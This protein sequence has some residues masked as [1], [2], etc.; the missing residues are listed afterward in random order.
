MVLLLVA[1]VLALGVWLVALAAARG[2]LT[3]NGA[4]GIRTPA[5][6][7]SQEAWVAAHRAALPLVAWGG[8]AVVAA[9][10]VVLLGGFLEP[11]GLET[12]GI[13]LVLAEGVLVVI[14]A[15]VAHRAAVQVPAP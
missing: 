9:A 6:Q 13:T 8:L 11:A 3:A 10:L 5:T 7:R 4:I 2:R 15:A 12:V 14:A 1:M